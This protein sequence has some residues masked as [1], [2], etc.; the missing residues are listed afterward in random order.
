M[1]SLKKYRLFVL[2]DEHKLRVYAPLAKEIGFN[3]HLVFMQLEFLASIST[4]E[5]K[6]GRLWT[7]QSIRDLQEKHF[8]FWSVAT[9]YRAI[10]SLVKKGL[11]VTGNFNSKKYDRTVWYS[12]EWGTVASTLKS[13]RAQEIDTNETRS[14][15]NETGFSQN[16]TTIP[17]TSSA[18]SSAKGK[19]S[20]HPMK[21]RTPEEIEA[22]IRRFM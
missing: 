18:T 22:A 6:M 20:F 16:E 3:E 1:K 5:P 14:L 19:R 21:E 2:N 9:I 4:T 8:P 12:I 13:V 10:Q 11:I 7:Y 15:Q 17:A